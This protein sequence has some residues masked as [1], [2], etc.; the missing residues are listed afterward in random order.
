MLQSFRSAA[1]RVL[2]RAKG[3]RPVILR[4]GTSALHY[5]MGLPLAVTSHGTA[6]Q[7][8]AESAEGSDA[9]IDITGAVG[10]E[11]DFASSASGGT[12]ATVSDARVVVLMD[13]IM[14]GMTGVEVMRALPP[15]VHRVCRFVAMTG[16]VDEGS[17][18]I[19]KQVGFIGVLRK[20]FGAT[21]LANAIRRALDSP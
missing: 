10:Q 8:Q 2:P 17:L 3:T 21:E 18:V 12:N 5:L 4:D 11:A 20:P 6:A 7:V 13:I 1:D 16:S 14:P 19:Y 9:V 15:A